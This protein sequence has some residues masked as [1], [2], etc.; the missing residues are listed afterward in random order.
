MPDITA[1]YKF[2]NGVLLF[3]ILLALLTP[4]TINIPNITDKNLFSTTW[5]PPSCFV[6]KLTGKPCPACGLTRSIVALYNGDFN[7]SLKYH[8][9]GYIFVCLLLL[10]FFL[11]LIPILCSHKM[12]PWIDLCQIIFV[13]LLFAKIVYIYGAKN[14]YP[15]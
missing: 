14:N 4:F 1:Q 10:E 6:K 12:V 11:R 3:M 15:M 7:L 2:V 13:S 5:S 8:Q 9:A